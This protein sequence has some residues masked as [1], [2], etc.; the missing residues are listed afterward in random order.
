MISGDRSP[1]RKGRQL[2]GTI[3]SLVVLLGLMIVLFPGTS[4]AAATA[5]NVA[6]VATVSASSQTASTGQFAVKAV[7]GVV[8][9]YPGDYTKEWATYGG[10]AGSWLKLAWPNPVMIN[11]IV[12]YDRPNTNDQIT[13]ATISFS[14]GSTLSTGTLANNGAAQT[15]VFAAK[16]VT[17]LKVTVDSVSYTTKNIG[18]SE[19][20]VWGIPS[21]GTPASTTPTTL[22]PTTTTTTMRRAATT[23]TTTQRPATVTTTLPATTTTTQRVATTTTTLPPTTTTTQRP[24][25]TMTTIPATTTTTL[26]AT[27]TTTLAGSGHVIT[28]TGSIQA[29]VNAAKDGDTIYIPAGTYDGIVSLGGKSNITIY[30]AGPSTI[31]THPESDDPIFEIT[32]G[33]NITL[34]DFAFQGDYD[35]WVQQCLCIDA[36]TTGHIY[37]IQFNTP[38]FV[39]INAR[40]PVGQWND[41]ITNLEIDHCQVV[42]TAGEFGVYLG[43]GCANVKLH[44]CSFDRNEG[45]MY[46]PHAVYVQDCHAIYVYNNYAVNTQ[47][48]PNGYAYK[49]GIDVYGPSHAYDIHFDNNY[50]ANGYGGL[51]L[52]SGSNITATGNT[53]ENMSNAGVA[54]WSNVSNSTISN[55]K[56]INCLYGVTFG[57]DN[58]WA[59]NI[60]L[61]GNTATGGIPID[62]AGALNL[63]ESGNSWNK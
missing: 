49:A 22:P 33:S 1:R 17:W 8:A 50:A 24:A 9:G 53:F 59:N 3:L 18:L 35:R 12:L 51:W 6:A 20:E 56:F 16:T 10:R 26:P 39:A 31:L 7:D 48:N 47:K 23:T 13:A 38:G 41:V 32:S 19:A 5:T 29:A 46:P 14:D 58:T 43:S 37:N 27:T 4:A 57:T 63:V 42:G 55:N 62:R 60:T 54:I 30:G 15:F 36:L 25:T 61:T 2:A 44:D 52:V 21:T 34:H 11:K 28:V 40:G 45:R